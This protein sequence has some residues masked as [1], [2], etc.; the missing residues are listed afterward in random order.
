[1][2]ELADSEVPIYNGRVIQE[3]SEM[4]SEYDNR[5]ADYGMDE[6]FL[7]GGIIKMMQVDLHEYYLARYQ[8]A[9][10]ELSLGAKETRES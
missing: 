9:W 7:Q 2:Q 4:P 8:E 10:E 5:W 6:T 3:W 1:L